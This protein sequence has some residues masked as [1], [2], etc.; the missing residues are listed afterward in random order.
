MKTTCEVLKKVGQL[1]QSHIATAT[2][3]ERFIAAESGDSGLI[4][5]AQ[6]EDGIRRQFRLE[7]SEV[8][9][10]PTLSQ[11]SADTGECCGNP[12]SCD[13]PPE[14]NVNASQENAPEPVETASAPSA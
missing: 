3:Q 2:G 4:V 13:S 12:E 6:G 7:V 9:E 8:D 14:E 5:T 11:P 1:V 10:A